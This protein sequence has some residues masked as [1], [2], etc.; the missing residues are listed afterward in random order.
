MVM[1]VVD[2]RDAE[3]TWS[4]VTELDKVSSGQRLGRCVHRRQA[5]CLGCFQSLLSP[6][7]QEHDPSYNTVGVGGV[8]FSDLMIHEKH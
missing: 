1:A 4:T 7:Q 2:G 8:C 3:E 6:Q 5:L